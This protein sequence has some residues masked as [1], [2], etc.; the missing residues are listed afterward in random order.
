MAVINYWLIEEDQYF[1]NK[2]F[3]R[4]CIDY[5]TC[6]HYLWMPIFSCKTMQL[7]KRDRNGDRWSIILR[8]WAE[9]SNCKRKN[10]R[11]EKEENK[12]YGIWHTCRTYVVLCV[13]ERNIKTVFNSF[14]KWHKKNSSVLIN[15]YNLEYYYR[16]LKYYYWFCVY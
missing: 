16:I 12:E 7:Q 2:N 8:V 10:F 4:P 15:L 14:F 1:L 13:R 11:K 3:I 6:L 5:F 9:N